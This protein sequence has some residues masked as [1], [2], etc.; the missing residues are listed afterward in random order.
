MQNFSGNFAEKHSP[1]VLISVDYTQNRLQLCRKML[2][3]SS[4]RIVD[5]GHLLFGEEDN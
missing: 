4:M 2:I 5:L 3:Y 1:K